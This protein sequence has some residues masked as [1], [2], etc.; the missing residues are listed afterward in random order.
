MAAA[1]L[2]AATRASCFV[3]L[4]DIP[5]KLTDAETDPSPKTLTAALQESF[6]CCCR[7]AIPP[8]LF[9]AVCLVLAMLEEHQASLEK[10]AE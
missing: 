2:S 1:L 3:C 7:G 8:V 6:L 9:R 5:S 10:K 4:S